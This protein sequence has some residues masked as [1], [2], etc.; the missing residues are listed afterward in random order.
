LLSAA[1]VARTDDVACV[2]AMF[3]DY[4]FYLTYVSFLN[5]K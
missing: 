3:L 2:I 5:M 1:L 4:L